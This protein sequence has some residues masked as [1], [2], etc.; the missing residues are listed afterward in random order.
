MAQLFPQEFC[1][2]FLP[3]IAMERVVGGRGRFVDK[4]ALL[5]SPFNPLASPHASVGLGTGAAGCL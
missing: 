2:S 3:R 5:S 4:E 1:L